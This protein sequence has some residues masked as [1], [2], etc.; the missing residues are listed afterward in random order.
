MIALLIC[1]CSITATAVETEQWNIFELTLE[2]PSTGNPFVDVELSAEFTQGSEVFKPDGFYDGNG[3]YKVRFMPNATGV[4]TYTTRSNCN[5][6]DGKKGSF[7]C[8]KAGPGNHGPVRVW[9]TYQL[10]YS[11]GTPHFS[12]GTTCYAWIHQGDKLEAE[13]LETLKNSPFNKIRM[14][15]FPKAYVYNRNEP[16]YYPY[17]GKPLKDWDFKH[18]NPAFWRHF[19]KRVGQLRDMGIEADIIIFHPYDRWGFKS[20]GHENN[21]FYLR[22]LV[23]RLAAYRNVW[24]SFANEYDF[25]KWPME[26]WDTYFRFVRKKDP[27]NHLRGIHNG[28]DWYDH[29]KEWVTH[30]SL[31]TSNFNAAREYR[32]KYKK[33]IIYDECRYEGNIPQGWG[34]ISAEQMTR[35][36][37]MG[38]LAGCY[39]G[40]GE[41]Y[42]HPQDILWWSKGGVLH[43]QSPARIQF[44]KDII[45]ELPYQQMQPDFSNYP[46]VRI[47]AKEG[48][49]YLMYFSGKGQVTLNLLG[50]KPY[51]VDGIDTWE[52]S[53]LPIGSASPGKFTISPPKQDY[54][55]R[56]TRYGPSEKMRLEATATADKLEGIAPLKVRFSTSWEQKCYWDFGDTGS[57][58][59]S[60]PVHTFERPGIY[61]V[62]LT[63][64]S[65]DGA[66]GCTMLPIS[67][68]RK[69]ND[70]VIK[71]GFSE[72]DYPK[73]T[74][75][76]NKIKRFKDGTYDLGTGEPFGW[77]KLGDGPI[78]KLGGARSF[79]IVGW[80][81][82]SSMKVGSGGNRILFNL[83]NNHSGIDLVHH[84][85]GTMRLA[86]NEWPDHIRNDSSTGK[87]KIG[88]WV[89]FAVTYD[90]S[91]QK[92]NV[93]WYFGDESTPAELDRKTSYNNGPVDEGS[94]DL[95]I[96]N[97]N[98]TLQGAG[99]DRQFRG[100]IRGLQIYA[101]RLG[102]RGVLSLKKIRGLQRMK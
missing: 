26:H 61:V 31:Q 42:K 15:V 65:E 97:F 68:D 13:T 78:S 3:I 5:E 102:G 93:C 83:Q 56:L 90:A 66:T 18:F 47:M 52:M 8:K 79:S 27:Y 11:D 35:N 75:Y 45:D 4:W 43:G 87:V 67:V 60:S 41:T 70:P 38:S 100:Q 92:D 51:K 98:K 95:V 77:I 55:I 76:G 91:E 36:F 94:S 19:E 17:E 74:L 44:M 7:T 9:N 16:E 96:G 88:K 21:L 49:C 86:V 6:L 58:A 82:A 14:C 23:A 84:A 71:F 69:S 10:A 85:D 59:D 29:T 80:I 32:D 25:L 28:R 89:F 2:G 33:P 37:W 46:D 64:S 62:T 101:S 53:I 39:V 30:A 12:V 34:N 20:M 72:G 22:Y 63:I 73:V 40:H 81:R 1:G 50:D 48:E 54:A 24:W 99:L 57:S